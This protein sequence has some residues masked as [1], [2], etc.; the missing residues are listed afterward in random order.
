MSSPPNTQLQS[1]SRSL[2]ALFFPYWL[3]LL[4]VFSLECLCSSQYV[5]VYQQVEAEVQPDISEKFEIVAVPTFVFVQVRLACFPSLL[6]PRPT[7]LLISFLCLSFNC[8]LIPWCVCVC[9][10]RCRMGRPSTEWREPMLLSSAR[11]SQNTPSPQPPLQWE[12]EPQQ[13]S[14]QTRRL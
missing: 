8:L 12:Q 1:S 3:A 14:S 10:W 9:V 6:T 5:C 7:D 13:H 2:L 4:Q 11:R